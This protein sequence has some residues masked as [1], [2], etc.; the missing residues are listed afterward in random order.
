MD[1]VP[2]GLVR[3]RRYLLPLDAFSLFLAVS[4]VVMPRMTRRIPAAASPPAPA[5]VRAE[6]ALLD[7]RVCVQLGDHIVKEHRWFPQSGD[8]RS[9]MLPCEILGRTF[10]S[11][12]FPSTPQWA[13][14]IVGLP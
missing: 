9:H 2:S 4:L 6:D 5:A 8:L 14:R 1:K 3:T 10:L 13:S 11:P 7:M 12:F